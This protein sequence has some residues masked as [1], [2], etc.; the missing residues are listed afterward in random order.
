MILA[1]IAHSIPLIVQSMPP[2]TIRRT[3]PVEVSNWPKPDSVAWWT[4][5]F[6]IG[7]VVVALVTLLAV[8]RQIVLATEELK[9]VKSDFALSQQ[10]FDLSQI[11]FNELMRRPNLSLTMTYVPYNY[12]DVKNYLPVQ[13]VLIVSNTGSKSAHEICVELLLM[14]EAIFAKASDVASSDVLPKDG[15][16]YF[17]V[18]VRD[19]REAVLYGNGSSIKLVRNVSVKPDTK[20]FPIFYRIFDDYGSYPSNGDYLEGRFDPAR[21]LEIRR[22]LLANRPHMQE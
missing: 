5:R 21:F 16:A 2:E 6:T 4:L 9:S 13:L 7:A 14:D 17:K 15:K 18:Q 8:L 20:G 22:L 12:E 1:A 11:Q 3:L 10:Q 19:P